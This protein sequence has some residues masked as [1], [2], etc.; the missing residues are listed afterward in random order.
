[1]SR[2]YRSFIPL[3]LFSLPALAGSSVPGIHNFYQVDN[4][5]Y[6]GAQPTNEGLSYLAKIGVKTVLDLR[7]PGERSAAEEHAVTA[8]GMQYV[9]VPMGG[10]TAPTAAQISK[11]L[12]LLEDKTT[13]PV[14]VH[15]RR[16]ADRT[17]AVI[18][19]YRVDFDHWDNARALREA[20][21]DGM[22]FFQLPRQ[23][24]IRSFQP[25]SPEAIEAAKPVEAKVAASAT[26]AVAVSG[27]VGAR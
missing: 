13:G 19:A 9:S 10:L 27:P 8:L 25:R 21:S 26:P 2:P 22:S 16:G 4:H 6:R 1:M 18:G 17:G 20:M 14:F 12:A 24:Y 3:F 7:E 11:I 15:C 5:V 23:S